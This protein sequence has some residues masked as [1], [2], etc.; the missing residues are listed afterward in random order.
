MDAD[1]YLKIESSRTAW[2]RAASRIALTS[3]HR[4]F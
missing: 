3:A 2:R 1:A 4:R